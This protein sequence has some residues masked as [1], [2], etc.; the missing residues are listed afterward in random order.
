MV[1]TTGQQL[2]LPVVPTTAPD[3]PTEE[4]ILKQPSLK[5]KNDIN[6]PIKDVA[7]TDIDPGVFNTE[8]VRL[9]LYV[10]PNADDPTQE[11]VDA[12]G[13]I[14]EG[15]YAG[16]QAALTH[17]YGRI[18]RGYESYYDVLQVESTLPRYNEVDTKKSLYQW[19][20][21]PTDADGKPSQYPPHLETIPTTDA[22]SPLAIFN[23]LGLAETKQLISQVVPDTFFGKTAAWFAK[24]AFHIANGNIE[25]AADQGLS[26]AAYE[27]YNRENRKSGQDIKAG[28]NI[29]LLSDWYSDRRFAEQAL[30]G[31]NPTSIISL[32]KV[33]GGDKLL[34]EFVEAAKTGKYNDW[35][36]ALP[37]KDKKNLFVLDNRGFRTAVK[38]KSQDEELKAKP[39][40]SKTGP[41]DN[42]DTN[43]ACAAVTLFELY[44]DG[45]LHPIAIV[46]DYKGSMKASVTIFNQRQTP[47]AK[48]DTEATDWPWR[49]AKTCA[50]VSDW[51]LH[52]VGV[53]LTRAHLIEEALI[54]GTH[55]AIDMKH[56]VFKLLE[57]HWYKTLSLNAAAR[58]T[59]VPQLV[60]ELVGFKEDYLYQFIRT[61]FENYDFVRNY[62]PNDLASRGFPNTTEGLSDNKYKNYAYARNM[63]SMWGTLKKYVK[64][65]LQTEYA[66]DAKVAADPALKAWTKEVRTGGWI[67][68]FPD[69]KTID[70]LADAVTMS[71]HI[72]APFHTAVNYL[73]NFYQ[74]FVIAKPPS[75]CQPLPQTLSELKAYTERSLIAALPCGRQ[76]QWLLSV[77]VPWLLSFKV[78]EERSLLSFSHAQWLTRRGGNDKDK[79]IAAISEELFNDLRKLIDQFKLN[80]KDMSKDSIPY[81]V[82]DPTDTAVSILI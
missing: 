6:V 20:A 49:Y 31:T 36:K 4:D 29:G 40:N 60:K 42:S 10:Q 37:S 69:I 81:I 27:A 26:L 77:Q 3:V 34:A 28:S 23:L 46:C 66:S 38:A 9:N 16:T 1:T 33:A 82:M 71:I 67:K 17:A 24:Q 80:S 75:L 73:Q 35:A 11:P 64:A 56:I 32:A 43:W 61:E 2:L 55:R 72:A 21:Y 39:S 15:T 50:Q 14:E 18:E 22:V 7:F 68:T 8:L 25:D 58:E 54:V 52:E 63:V 57:P 76:R 59:L 19:S 62:V 5:D 65:V 12:G 48:T 45:K 44:P 41:N 70:D 30:T 78:A 79:K 51:L 13:N 47:D 74:A 53:H